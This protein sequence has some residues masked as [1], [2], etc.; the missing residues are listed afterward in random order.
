MLATCAV[1]SSNIQRL[2]SSRAERRSTRLTDCSA[3][4]L[5]TAVNTSPLIISVGTYPG[6]VGLLFFSPET[7]WTEQTLSP[8][9][10]CQAELSVFILQMAAILCFQS[11]SFGNR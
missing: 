11:L 9:D 10:G 4:V 1:S 2:Q 5:A 7:K 3:A 8:A 6:C